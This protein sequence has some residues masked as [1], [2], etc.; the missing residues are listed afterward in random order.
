M[1][2]DHRIIQNMGSL[3]LAAVLTFP[4][5]RIAD[6]LQYVVYP[7]NRT[8]KSA[9]S[10]INDYLIRQL[11][12][13][14]VRSYT[15]PVRG[16]TEFWFVNA[17]EPELS[18]ILHDL[19]VGLRQQLSNSQIHLTCTAQGEYVLLNEI[20]S[21]DCRVDLSSNPQ[22]NSAAAQPTLRPRP[23]PP[24]RTVILQPNAPQDLGLISWPSVKPLPWRM[25]GYV[26]DPSFGTDTYLYVIDNGLN[27]A[28]PPKGRGSKEFRSVEWKYGYNVDSRP[29]DDSANGHGTCV[30]SK[31]VGW[32]NG[33]SKNT[34]L[35]ILKASLSLVDDN[36]A[37]AA[38]LDDIIAKNRQGKSVVLY[39]RTSIRQ[40][41]V[42]TEWEANWRS[43][44]S[45]IQDLFAQ[46]VIVVTCARNDAT[47]HSSVVNTVPAMWTTS[48]FSLVVAGAATTAGDFAR[49]SRGTTYP[50]GIVWAPGDE[51]WCT[52][53]NFLP[54]HAYPI[55]R[56]A[57]GSSFYAGMVCCT[58]GTWPLDNELTF[59]A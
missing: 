51:V 59:D 8:D 52:R 5:F 7:P 17:I 56:K 9:C 14:N 12:R 27:I 13:E 50:G 20:V 15:S 16:V 49:F 34:G 30:A 3:L 42:S 10:T 22:A 38:A 19:G 54:D 4:F 35:V 25:K 1:T 2:I 46:D 24:P 45:L 21:R 37:F 47:R 55:Q 31:A 32:K 48:D 26:Y 6:G 39:P 43:I 11:H 44:K 57:S 23:P 18:T 29:Q 40:Y 53:G 33:V 58:S 28:N 36:W 41:S